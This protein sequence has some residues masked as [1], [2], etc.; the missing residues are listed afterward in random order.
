MFKGLEAL[1]GKGKIKYDGWDAYF[2]IRQGVTAG[3][4][5]KVTFDKTL[6]EVRACK[7]SVQSTQYGNLPGMLEKH[8]QQELRE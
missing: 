6:K 5:E 3:L 1:K 4:L 8:V 2:I 7:Q